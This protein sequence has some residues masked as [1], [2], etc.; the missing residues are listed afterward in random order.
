[1]LKG[2]L[3]A[4]IVVLGGVIGMTG[5]SQVTA[6]RDALREIAGDLRTL[7][8]LLVNQGMKLCDALTC[9]AA[10]SRVGGA[11]KM[12]ARRLTQTSDSAEKT[13]EESGAMQELLEAELNENHLRLLDLVLNESDS[14]YGLN[15]SNTVLLHKYLKLQSVVYSNQKTSGGHL[16]FIL[17]PLK[18]ETKKSLTKNRRGIF[19]DREFLKMRHPA[20]PLRQISPGFRKPDE[21]QNQ[22]RN[23]IRPRIFPHTQQRTELVPKLRRQRLNFTKRLRKQSFSRSGI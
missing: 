11:Y 10:G 8:N 21:S 20:S 3:L 12:L 1:M 16:K 6:R 13:V 23:K 22:N 15:Y 17:D 9:V 4:G 5:V 14:G 2:I 19:H 18:K 7:E